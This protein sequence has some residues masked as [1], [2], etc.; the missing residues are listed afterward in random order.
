MGDYKTYLH[1]WLQLQQQQ[2]H[3]P[4]YRRQPIDQPNSL[5]HS[6]TARLNFEFSRPTPTWNQALQSYSWGLLWSNLFRNLKPNCLSKSWGPNRLVI[7]YSC[8]NSY[9]NE[10]SAAAAACKLHK[11]SP[12]VIPFVLMTC[13]PDY[14][15][16]VNKSDNTNLFQFAAPN[17][18]EHPHILS[19]DIL[20]FC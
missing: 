16:L 13:A 10:F 19:S 15:N 4:Q 18:S 20:N 11:L 14:I 17:T 1:R 5:T 2:L 12:A 6:S 8:L 3:T 7:W 9:Q